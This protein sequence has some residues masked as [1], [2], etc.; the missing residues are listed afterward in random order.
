[1]PVDDIATMNN[2]HCK[3][4]AIGQNE[5]NRAKNSNQIP[6]TKQKHYCHDTHFVVKAVDLITGHEGK[7]EAFTDTIDSKEQDIKTMT[8]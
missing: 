7:T 3:V 6:G 4:A 5:A 8:S 1:M 2:P